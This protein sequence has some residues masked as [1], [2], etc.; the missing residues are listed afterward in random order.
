MKQC[1]PGVCRSVEDV[2]GDPINKTTLLWLFVSENTDLSL[3]KY[4][5]RHVRVR[6]EAETLSAEGQDKVRSIVRIGMTHPPPTQITGAKNN[7]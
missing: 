4:N 1:P 5:L 7:Q 2:T 3:L 6:S